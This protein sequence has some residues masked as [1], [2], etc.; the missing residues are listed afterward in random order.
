[1][2][3]TTTYDLTIAGN[4]Y[5]G[6]EDLGQ[7]VIEQDGEW[8]ATVGDPTMFDFNLAEE[9][10]AAALGL[11]V[12]TLWASP[13]GGDIWGDASYP[14]NGCTSLRWEIAVSDSEPKGWGWYR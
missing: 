4:G 2:T 11:D 13:V 14:N 9:A 1:M 12:M 8:L 3:T 5:E 7:A 10:V 6:D